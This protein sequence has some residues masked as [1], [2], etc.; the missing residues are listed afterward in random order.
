MCFLWM[1][2]KRAGIAA[3]AAR[4][5][6]FRASVLNSTRMQPSSPKACSRRR[7]FASAF[8]PVP[9]AGRASQ[10]LP[11]SSPRCSG[12][13]VRKLVLPTGRPSRR[14]VANGTRSPRAAPASASSTQPRK[15]CRL[16]PATVVMKRHTS[17]SDAASQRGSSWRRSSGSR[18]TS[19]PSSRSERRSHTGWI[20]S[21]TGREDPVGLV[22]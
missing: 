12:R 19:C 13:S 6:S 16:A 2:S 8:A 11:I 1:P 22:P 15:S 9:Q 21:R 7:S 4:A 20:L 3:R 17:G 14:T 10:V 18:T 5:R